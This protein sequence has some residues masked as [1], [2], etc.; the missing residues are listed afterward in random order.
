[1]EFV[2]NTNNLIKDA[3]EYEQTQIEKISSITNIP[4]DFLGGM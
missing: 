4:M 1:M 3:M 2:E